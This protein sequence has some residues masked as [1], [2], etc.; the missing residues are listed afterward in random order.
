MLSRVEYTMKNNCQFLNYRKICWEMYILQELMLPCLINR[1]FNKT[2]RS[3]WASWPNTCIWTM[4]RN[5]RWFRKLWT[6]CRVE[7]KFLLLW[8][9]Q[10]YLLAWSWNVVWNRKASFS[11]YIFNN[12]SWPQRLFCNI[13]ESSYFIS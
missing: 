7:L 5:N 12:I 4:Q 10:D 2:R 11:Y 3:Q 8:M 6:V 1:N 9:L 13:H